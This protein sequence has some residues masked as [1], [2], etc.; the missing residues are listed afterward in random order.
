MGV[1][2][3]HNCKFGIANNEL[4]THYTTIIGFSDDKDSF[5]CRHFYHYGQNL[6]K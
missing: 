4:P 5:T 3:R 2:D 6:V 1:C